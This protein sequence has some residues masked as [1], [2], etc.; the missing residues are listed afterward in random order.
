MEIEL[1]E[2]DKQKVI[3]NLLFDFDSCILT[4]SSI[5]DNW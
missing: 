2:L 4:L 1:P 5:N 3:S